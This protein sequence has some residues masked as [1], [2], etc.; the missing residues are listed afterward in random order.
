MIVK[1]VSQRIETL[2]TACSHPLPGFAAQ[3]LMAPG[4]RLG[5]TKDP[6]G[7]FPSGNGFSDSSIR[8]S[9]IRYRKAAVLIL[10]HPGK[11][12]GPSG[13][14]LRFPLI[15]R[16]DTMRHHSGQIGLPGGGLEPG[17]SPRE[18]ALRE[19]FEELGFRLDPGCVIGDLSPLEVPHSGYLVYP[20]VAY[21][22]AIPEFH[23]ER[24]EV[25]EIIEADLDLLLDPSCRKIEERNFGGAIWPV[26][27][28]SFG[29]HKV[30]G[31]T[32]M[33]LAELACILS[34]PS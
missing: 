32:A 11:E 3:S 1:P 6:V 13:G 2:K 17:E 24:S 9:S 23:A 20:S 15:R 18:A 33:I 7:Q 28:Y 8:D 34:P 26:P 10:L 5:K 14:S 31:A 27:F 12:G 16:P 21:I 19:T 22:P 29:N 25:D 30:W 4:Y